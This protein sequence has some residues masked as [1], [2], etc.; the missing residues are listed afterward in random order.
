MGPAFGFV[1]RSSWTIFR[2]T[3]L[4]YTSI[5][6]V[7]LKRK[8]SVYAHTHLNVELF[9]EPEIVCHAIKAFQRPDLRNHVP[10]LWFH[11][12][13]RENADG[14]EDLVVVSALGLGVSILET[15]ST[16]H[17][18]RQGGPLT[19]ETWDGKI[20]PDSDSRSRKVQ[21]NR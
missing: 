11:A 20:S 2:T 12:G 4:T 19:S 9:S 8:D 3:S 7:G 6:R 18:S 16:H 1:A 5:K 13:N 15:A 21:T 17:N 10:I 14:E